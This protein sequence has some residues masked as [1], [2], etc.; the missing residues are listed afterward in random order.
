M[1]AVCQL[2][3]VDNRRKTA[4]DGEALSAQRDHASPSAPATP[5][6][7]KA[8]SR[9][10]TRRNSVPNQRGQTEAKLGHYDRTTLRGHESSLLLLATLRGCELFLVRFHHGS[11]VIQSRLPRLIRSI[12]GVG[13]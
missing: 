9:R 5:S 2:P 8:P 12:R 3:I 1:C 13:C 6:S 11:K 7:G 10:D 4:R